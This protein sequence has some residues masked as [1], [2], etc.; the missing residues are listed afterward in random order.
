[1]GNLVWGKPHVRGELCREPFNARACCIVGA[2]STVMSMALCN[3]KQV[4]KTSCKNTHTR[5]APS[6]STVCSS[7]KHMACP[8]GLS[9]TLEQTHGIRCLAIA[10]ACNVDRIK[11]AQHGR[12]T[13]SVMNLDDEDVPLIVEKRRRLSEPAGHQE[14]T[15]QPIE[16]NVRKTSKGSSSGAALHVV[17]CSQVRFLEDKDDNKHFQKCSERSCSRT[18]REPPCMLPSPMP[19]RQV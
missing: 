4:L 18:G 6:L 14:L 15:I 11:A 5:F 13:T 3:A 12:I 2:L 10:C 1:M 7:S 9:R 17:Q 8:I 16:H 19:T